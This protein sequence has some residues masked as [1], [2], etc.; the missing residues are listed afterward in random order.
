MKKILI[1]MIIMLLSLSCTLTVP[2]L[3]FDDKVAT[4]AAV[5][6]TA[7]ALDRTIRTEVASPDAKATDA[8]E[9]TPEPTETLPVGDPRK[10]LGNPTRKD[11]LTSSGIWFKDSDEWVTDNTKFSAVDGYIAA[12]SSTVT[13][14][15]RWYL[16]FQKIGDAY[17]EAKFDV[18]T[19]AGSDKYG[20]VFKAVDFDGTDQFFYSI[21]CEGQYELRKM[22][23]LATSSLIPI[24]ESDKINAG[25]NQSN[26]LGVWVKNSRIRLYVNGQFLQEIESSGIPAEGHYGLFINARQTPGL[27]VHLDEVTYWLFE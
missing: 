3:S 2:A 16:Y 22:I 26:I 8:E 21:T 24:S 9:E 23:S 20:L 5:A 19:C 14:G 25:S 18:T 10:E 12:T 4:Q 6:M 1:F 13:D 11:N 15:L 17:I 27:T 7:T